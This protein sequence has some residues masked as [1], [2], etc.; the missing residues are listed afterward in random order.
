VNRWDKNDTVYQLTSL[1][2]FDIGLL[3]E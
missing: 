1:G 3:V 2:F